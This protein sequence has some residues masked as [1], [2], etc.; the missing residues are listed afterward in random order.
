MRLLLS[1]LLF[2]LASSASLAAPVTEAPRTTIE[3]IEET[4]IVT[5]I[6]YVSYLPLPP[7]LASQ[8]NF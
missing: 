6:H 3:T 8:K 1:S 4:R 2:L 7:P 5:K